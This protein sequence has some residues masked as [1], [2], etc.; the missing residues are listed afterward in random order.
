M[1]V[2]NKD[3]DLEGLEEQINFMQRRMFSIA[4]EYGRE[5]RNTIKESQQLDQLIIQYMKQKINIS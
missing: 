1:E 4:D 3:M 5:S 2:Y